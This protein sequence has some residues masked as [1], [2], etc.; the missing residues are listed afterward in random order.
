M[1]MKFSAALLVAVGNATR[2]VTDHHADYFGG[3]A[4]PSYD[5]IVYHEP[6]YDYYADYGH[7]DHYYADFGGHDHH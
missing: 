1:N 7:D 3:F 6:H 2:E 5:D 4:P